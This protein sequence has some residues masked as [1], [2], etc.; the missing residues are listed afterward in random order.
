MIGGDVGGSVSGIKR[1][2]YDAIF[3]NLVR[4]RTDYTCE[5]CGHYE[6][7]GSGRQAMHCSHF[8]SRGNHAVRYDPLNALCICASCHK[9]LGENPYEHTKLAT[10]IFGVVLMDLLQE[11]S[12]RIMRRR[13]ADLEE[14][15]QHYKGEL[16]KMK[17]QRASGAAGRLEFVGY[18]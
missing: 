14:M 7:P 11:K 6:P 3:S 13:K 5:R 16:A 12:R 1:T 18:D 10:S 4:E 17:E 2:K 8:I 15:Y 9:F